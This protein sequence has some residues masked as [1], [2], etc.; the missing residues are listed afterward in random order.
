MVARGRLGFLLRE[1]PIPAIGDPPNSRAAHLH[2]VNKPLISHI[3]QV[4]INRLAADADGLRN[5]RSPNSRRKV[6]SN[7]FQDLN[8]RSFALWPWVSHTLQVLLN[9]NNW[10]GF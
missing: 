3:A 5:I 9:R 1:S 8:L 6:V 4:L 10:L 7:S 2:G